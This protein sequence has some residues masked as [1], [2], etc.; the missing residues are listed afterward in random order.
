MQGQ[1]DTSKTQEILL[2]QRRAIENLEKEIDNLS[3]ASNRDEKR[4]KD[5]EKS[6]SILRDSLKRN[7]DIFRMAA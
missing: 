5:L 6:A 7:Q 2:S 3:V 4:I 1:Y